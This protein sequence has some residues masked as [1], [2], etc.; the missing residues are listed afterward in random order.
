MQ[1]L[2]AAKLRDPTR[3]VVKVRFLGKKVKVV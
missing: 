3:I 2:T 1:L